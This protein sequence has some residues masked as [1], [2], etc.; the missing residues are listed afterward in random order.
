M[1]Y[2]L[3]YGWQTPDQ[4][5]QSTLFPEN[6][7]V[8]LA[9]ASVSFD[10]VVRW[11]DL[12]WISFDPTHRQELDD[13]EVM[14]LLFIRNIARSGLSVAIINQLLSSLNKPYSYHP[15]RVVYSFA[16]G[17]VQIPPLPEDCD[18]CNFFEAHMDQWIRT[19]LSR[20]ETEE[21][22]DVAY[23]ILGEIASRNASKAQIRKAHNPEDEAN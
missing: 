17:W 19:R 13:P 11:Q 18:I 20:D 4:I 10:E 2:E 22:R 23:A 21:L 12:G 8:V 3:P 5:T 6:T 15:R 1:N 16:D 14:E 9:S 7:E